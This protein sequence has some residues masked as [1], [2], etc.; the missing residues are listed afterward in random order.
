MLSVISLYSPSCDAFF[1][2]QVT[3]LLSFYSY[4]SHRNYAD[5]VGLGADWTVAPPV[6]HALQQDQH[7]CG[8]YA[9]SVSYTETEY[10]CC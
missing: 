1:F 9:L 4:L 6:Q 7:S 2:W 5:A 10:N 8:V 3:H